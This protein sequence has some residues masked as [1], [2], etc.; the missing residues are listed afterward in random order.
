LTLLIVSCLFVLSTTFEGNAQNI[1]KQ[2]L[3]QQGTF[4]SEKAKQSGDFKLKKPG[5]EP[6]IVKGCGPSFSFDLIAGV[7]NCPKC[8]QYYTRG[9]DAYYKCEA[10]C[11]EG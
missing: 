2:V 7:I 5:P 3:N 8:C 6:T 11:F 1:E 10:C 9:G 4:S